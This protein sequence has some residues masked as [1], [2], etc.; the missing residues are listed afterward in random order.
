MIVKWKGKFSSKRNLNGGGPQGGTLGIW[1]YLSQTNGNLDFV[2]QDLQ[3]KFVDDATVLEIVNLLSIGLASPFF[4]SRVAS[5]IAIDCKIVPSHNLKSQKYLDEINRWS[6]NQKMELNLEKTKVMI[7]NF[8]TKNKFTTNLCLEGKN[9]EVVD[10]TKLL[11]TIITSDLKWNK[12]TEDIVKR[13]YARMQIIHRLSQYKPKKEDIIHV[14]KLYVRSLLEQSCQIWHSSL[15]DQNIED[16]ERVQKSLL[17]IIEPE[18]PYNQALEKTG[19]EHLTERRKN[20]CLKFAKKCV[21]NPKTTHMFKQT[22][23]IGDRKRKE[24]FE[25][26]FARTERL[27]QSSIPYMQRLLNEDTI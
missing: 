13:S 14:Y 11:G 21:E 1:E 3:Y 23:N 24:K 16:L 2:D 8:S 5:N 12:N 27:K 20:L 15:T 26:Q 10:H 22:Q 6:I 7:F 17:R 25:V 19:L 9:I 4:K 18:L